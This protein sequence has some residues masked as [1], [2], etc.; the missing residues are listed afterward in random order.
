MLST[1]CFYLI[2]ISLFQCRRGNPVF[3]KDAENC[4]SLIPIKMQQK[5]WL[6]GEYS[7]GGLCNQLFGVFSYVPFAR[8]LKTN[9]I[10]GPIYSRR[11]F[12]TTFVEFVNSHIELPFSYLFDINHFK[13]FWRKE[14]LQIVER[15]EIDPCLNIS[16]FS[17]VQKPHF[18]SYSDRQLIDMM[19]ESNITLPLTENVNGIR[20]EGGHKFTALYNHLQSD[21]DKTNGVS[22]KQHIKQVIK[23]P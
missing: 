20:L 14:G 18:F 16:A 17:I 8:L 13:S 22:T 6:L 2:V 1:L 15:H 10:I 19:N 3:V 23:F 7:P 12:T 9:L 5:P 21:E 4:R 11:S